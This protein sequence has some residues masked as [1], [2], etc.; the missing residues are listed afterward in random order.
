[1]E[2]YIICGVIVIVGVAILCAVYDMGYE[3]GYNQALLGK[4]EPLMDEDE[5]E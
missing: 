2:T 3:E 4:M 5:I 1:M